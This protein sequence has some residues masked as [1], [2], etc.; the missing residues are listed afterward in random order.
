MRP[1]LPGL[2]QQAVEPILQIAPLFQQPPQ[3]VAALRGV[4]LARVAPFG[5]LFHMEIFRLRPAWKCRAARPGPRVD[6]YRKG[7]VR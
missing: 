4:R 3:L 1:P 5:L 7:T 6:E 2:L